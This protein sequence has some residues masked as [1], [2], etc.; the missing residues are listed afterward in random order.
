MAM[1]WNALLSGRRRR[2]GLT[3][4]YMRQS[5]IACSFPSRLIAIGQRPH[6]F[7][8]SILLSIC[9]PK[10]AD[11][12]CIH[13]RR[14]FRRRPACLFLASVSWRASGKNVPCVVEVNN[15]FEA[16]EIAIVAIGFDELRIRP[17]VHIPKR[18]DLHPAI[19]VRCVLHPV[20]IRDGRLTQEMLVLQ[21]CA[22]AKIDVRGAI[23]VCHIAK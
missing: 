5:T 15:L 4:I 2:G 6:K 3:P 11:R 8:K 21:K 16:F 12:F 10:T 23:C 20:C 1:L 7:D 9:Q 14:S 18:W 22:H 19:V 17:L 13:I